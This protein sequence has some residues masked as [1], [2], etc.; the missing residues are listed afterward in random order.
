MDSTT[1]ITNDQE[2]ISTYRWGFHTIYSMLFNYKRILDELSRVRFI[3]L[4]EIH[5]PKFQNTFNLY[6]M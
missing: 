3:T 4:L 2:I 6:I 1:Q 5:T